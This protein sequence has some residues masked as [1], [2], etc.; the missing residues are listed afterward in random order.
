MQRDLRFYFLFFVLFFL[1][2]SLGLV[3][4]DIKL[5]NEQQ[6]IFQF[7]LQGIEL[8]LL[9]LK[10]LFLLQEILVFQG[11]SVSSLSQFSRKRGKL[12]FE[13]LDFSLKVSNSFKFKT[14]ELIFSVTNIS[15]TENIF[16]LFLS[17][18]FL[19]VLKLFFPLVQDFLVRVYF[20]HEGGKVFTDFVDVFV[21]FGNSFSDILPFTKENV[22]LVVFLLE[23]LGSFIKLDLAGL[24]G[25][26]FLL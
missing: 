2:S 18:E 3:F 12:I 10:S 6:L 20:I 17:V 11:Y 22:S 4:G 5:L 25:G 15:V 13:D 23:L 16:S 9:S 8:S 26:N 14:F 24:G 1:E 7:C 19:L 21:S